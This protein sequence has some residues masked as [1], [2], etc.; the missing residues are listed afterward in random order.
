[1]TNSA[2]HAQLICHAIYTSTI[3]LQCIIGT[4][5]QFGAAKIIEIL[6]E[7]NVEKMKL[8]NEAWLKNQQQQVVA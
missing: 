3:L 8:I 2:P 6:M 1:M 7:R 4:Y 5:L